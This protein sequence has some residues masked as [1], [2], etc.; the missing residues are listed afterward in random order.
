MQF[1]QYDFFMYS[2]FFCLTFFKAY[3]YL[4]NSIDMRAQ[5]FNAE[6]LQCSDVHTMYN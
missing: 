5:W 6:N 3:I 4:V 1:L 2:I